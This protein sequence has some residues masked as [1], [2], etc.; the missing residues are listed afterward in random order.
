MAEPKKIQKNAA[1]KKKTTPPAMSEITPAAKGDMEKD[2]AEAYKN[3]SETQSSSVDMNAAVSSMTASAE[4]S[5]KNSQKTGTEANKKTGKKNVKK[6]AGTATNKA[7]VVATKKEEKAEE[8]ENKKEE[9]V[10]IEKVVADPA[11]SPEIKDEIKEELS[12]KKEEV[13]AEEKV[14]KETS[15]APASNETAKQQ[16]EPTSQEV[17]EDPEHA[18]I[19]KKLREYKTT[20]V[21]KFVESYANTPDEASFEDGSKLDFVTAGIG[22]TTAAVMKNDTVAAAAAHSGNVIAAGTYAADMYSMAGERNSGT[23]ESEDTS[24]TKLA[25]VGKILAGALTGVLAA[26]NAFTS[27]TNTDD[28]T[29]KYKTVVGITKVFN[30]LTALTAIAVD[31]IQLAGKMS[32]TA[33]AKAKACLAPVNTLLSIVNMYQQANIYQARCVKSMQMESL[34]TSKSE[35][36]EDVTEALMKLS[37]QQQMKAHILWASFGTQ[38][39]HSIAYCKNP[40]GVGAFLTRTSTFLAEGASTAYNSHLYEKEKKIG[41]MV[42]ADLKGIADAKD[43]TKENLAY[44]AQDSRSLPTDDNIPLEDTNVYKLNSVAEKELIV[45]KLSEVDHMVDIFVG[46]GEYETLIKA[47]GKNVKRHKLINSIGATL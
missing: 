14:E 42:G 2:L 32:A 27:F 7:K 16:P 37:E 24:M 15:E 4:A 11:T 30:V 1:P 9:I 44:L 41:N 38:V 23:T 3:K 40:T 43:V 34:S 47:K 29:Q 39:A 5:K 25:S 20:N 17:E 18:A 46:Y 26:I 36:L 33:V 6:K 12:N 22:N 10:Q 19:N 31:S 21:A 13:A 35:H 45:D 28:S 8:K